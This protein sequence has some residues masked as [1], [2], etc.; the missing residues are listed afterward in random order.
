MNKTYK[1]YELLET[2]KAG[3]IKEGTYFDMYL[4]GNIYSAIVSYNNDRLEWKI[5]YFDFW[6]FLIDNAEF[7]ISERN[8]EI[9]KQQLKYEE[10][11][12]SDKILNPI[13][14]FKN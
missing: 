10:I 9:N 7:K 4:N 3:G 11:L 8:D 1:G 14:E 6:N 13:Y 2:I 5:E 12:K